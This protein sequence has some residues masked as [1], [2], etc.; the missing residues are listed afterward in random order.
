MLIYKATS[1]LDSYLPDLEFTEDTREAEII[2]VG[3]KRFAFEDFPKLAGIFKTGVGTDNLPFDEAQD[4]G[5]EIALPS[6]KTCDFIFE[7]TASFSCHLILRGLYTETGVWAKWKK[8]NRK[9]LQSK[10]LLVVGAGRIG[11][12]VAD[13]M[14]AFLQVD[15]FDT[16]THSWAVF[17]SKVRLADC[18]SIHVPLNAETKGLFNAV[19]LAWLPDGA[20]LVNTARAPIVD[21]NDLYAELSSGRL[22]AA[23][24]VFWEE[25]YTGILT[26]LPADRFI[27]TPHIASTCVEFVK[28]ATDDFLQFLEKIEAKRG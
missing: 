3:G 5:V 20:L 15:T 1:T 8:H 25:P 6:S 21:E 7:E 11:Q 4:R 26:E 27:R 17:E 23:V 14:E 13:K 9:A 12:R 16:A 22:R 24:D 2:L 18:V 28:G 10:R 19:R